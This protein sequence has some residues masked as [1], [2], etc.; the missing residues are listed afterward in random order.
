MARRRSKKYIIPQ[1][2]T[3]EYEKQLAAQG[4]GCWIC[5][6]KPK[7]I[8]LAGDHSHLQQKL[9]GKIVRRGLLCYPC[10]RYVVKTIERWKID[11]DR[12]AEY[13]RTFGY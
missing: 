7:N 9:T 11:A 2:S 4:G 6:R 10:N 13:F 1:L 5:G 12:L 3:G 8:R